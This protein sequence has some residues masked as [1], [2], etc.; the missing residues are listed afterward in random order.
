MKKK[1]K[2][3]STRRKN[4]KSTSEKREI[5][6]GKVQSLSSLRPK[7]GAGDV[8]NF[9]VSSHRIDE[10]LSISNFRSRNFDFFLISRVPVPR[11]EEESQEVHEATL[12]IQ[13]ELY[14]Q[15]F[16]KSGFS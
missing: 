11:D 2:K 16:C 4:A 3:N 1:M 6:H 8:R 14:V 5:N 15:K 12:L 13:S 9:F 7:I 10:F